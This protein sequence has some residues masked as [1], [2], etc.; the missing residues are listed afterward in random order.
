[1]YGTSDALVGYAYR[2]CLRS[3][4]GQSF[5]RSRYPVDAILCGD[6]VVWIGRGMIQKHLRVGAGW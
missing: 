1:M 5:L 2:R 3:R 6:D 4:A